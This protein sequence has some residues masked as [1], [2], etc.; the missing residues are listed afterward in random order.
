MN[1]F[2]LRNFSNFRFCLRTGASTKKYINSLKKMCIFHVWLLLISGMAP[3]AYAR[4][5]F[6]SVW[7]INAEMAKWNPTELLLPNGNL[8]S[9][10]ILINRIKMCNEFSG[11][12]NDERKDMSLTLCVRVCVS[13]K[14]IF[15]LF[16]FPFK[17]RTHF[18]GFSFFLQ[19]VCFVCWFLLPSG[20]H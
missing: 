7:C 14:Y 10:E 12:K 9:I 6:C 2:L 5:R 19:I 16:W 20:F 4:N 18:Y 15:F 13:D 17:Y 11:K 3:V 8:L 1:V